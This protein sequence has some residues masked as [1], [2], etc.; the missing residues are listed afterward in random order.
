[1]I[2]INAGTVKA[3]LLEYVGV[4]QKEH[5]KAQNDILMR[6]AHGMT[7]KSTSPGCNISTQK[8]LRWWN[9]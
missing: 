9:N 2:K 5:A 8:R 4:A 6:D 3:A 7:P 1:M